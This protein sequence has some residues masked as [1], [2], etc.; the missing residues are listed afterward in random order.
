MYPCAREIGMVPGCPGARVR[1]CPGQ[2]GAGWML[3]EWYADIDNRAHEE[4]CHWARQLACIVGY[5][6]SLWSTFDDGASRIARYLTGISKKY[7]NMGIKVK[8]YIYIYIQMSKYVCVK[9]N[10]YACMGLLLYALL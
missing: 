3:P 5:H 2:R 8:A 4:Q 1:V 6:E 9:K 10:R 7:Q